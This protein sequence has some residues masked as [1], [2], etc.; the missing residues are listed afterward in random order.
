V[1]AVE[2]DDPSIGN[3]WRLLRRI[4][5]VVGGT[6]AQIVWDKSRNAWVPTSLAF[7]GHPDNPRA[8]SVHLEPVLLENGFDAESVVLDKSKFG[9]AT[10]TAAEARTQNQ[11]LM[12]MPLPGEPAHAH[13][14]GEKTGGI[15]RRLKN[16]AVWVIP[17]NLPPPADNGS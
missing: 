9:L 13:V 15:R 2:V 1:N 4:P 14:L 10:F 6:H 16:C 12:R 5:L 17:P 8:F 7:N 3:D 11:V